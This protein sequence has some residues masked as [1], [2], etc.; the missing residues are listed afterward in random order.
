MGVY[1]KFGRT[2]RL[3]MGIMAFLAAVPTYA[4][5]GIERGLG[6]YAVPENMRRETG[7]DPAESAGLF[8]GIGEFSDENQFTEIPFA[9]DDAVDLAYVFAL[10][11]RLV[12]PEN[13]VLALSGDT[14]K[15]ESRQRLEQ[16]REA[17]A[18]IETATQAD[19]Y[20]HVS[21]QGARSGEQGIYIVAV[22]THG[23]NEGGG[24][25]CRLRHAAGPHHADGSSGQRA[26]R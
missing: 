13:V 21:E 3:L 5:D 7:F 20:E 22:A 11:L 1:R 18:R 25:S 26:D 14:Q 12:A 2:S 4:D 8:V 19:I 15:P 23:F 17:G 6:V 16:L 24:L 10:D 9:V